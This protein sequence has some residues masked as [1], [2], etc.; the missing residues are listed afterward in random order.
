MLLAIDIGNSNIVLGLFKDT[1]LIDHW[2]IESTGASIEKQ[3]LDLMNYLFENKIKTS[4][5][6]SSI[7]SSVVPELTDPFANLITKIFGTHPVIIGAHLYHDLPIKTHSPYE[8][9]TDLMANALAAYTKCQQACIVIDFGTALTVTTISDSG[10]ILGVAIAPGLKTAI[11]SLSSSTAQLP[12]VE[13]KKP[14]SALGKNTTHAIQAGILIGYEGLVKELINSIQE[15]L[16]IKCNI[17]ATGGLVHILEGVKNLCDDVDQMLT[18]NGIRL[19]MEFS[20]KNK[21]V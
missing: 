20:I 1:V 15:E 12:D 9:G 8:I 5:I 7:L 11:K 18:L 13:L 16:T 3:E 14:L 19:L 21:F 6:N 17:V 4:A 2:R 10:E